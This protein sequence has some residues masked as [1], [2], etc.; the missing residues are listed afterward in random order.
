MIH[1][2]SNMK[3]LI[4]ASSLLVIAACSLNAQMFETVLEA[5]E[6]IFHPSHFQGS[7]EAIVAGDG[8]MAVGGN[9]LARDDDNQNI[10]NI[11]YT[12]TDGVTF[13][14]AATTVDGSTRLYSGAFGGGRFVFGGSTGEGTTLAPPQ[15]YATSTDGSNWEMDSF[16]D[17]E[18]DGFFE[19]QGMAYGDGEFVG[20][21]PGAALYT[22]TNGSDW[23]TTISTVGTFG[24]TYDGEQF[25][26]AGG[27]VGSAA[28]PSGAW[29]REA[30]LTGQAEEIAYGEGAYVTAGKNI[31]GRGLI[32][33]SED[34]ETWEYY[35]S[36]LSVNYEDLYSAAGYFVAVGGQFISYSSDG[37]TWTD[38][39]LLDEGISGGIT[40]VGYAMG[41]WYIGMNAGGSAFDPRI[42]RATDEFPPQA[43]SG[44]SGGGSVGGL[45]TAY[46]NAIELGGGWYWDANLGP[47]YPLVGSQWAY[48]MTAGWIYA[49]G[50]Y[51][52]QLYFYSSTSQSWYY[53]S[54]SINGLVYDFSGGAWLQYEGIS[55]SYITP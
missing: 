50:D 2:K 27:S 11:I 41:H 19:M 48:T 53:T 23:T 15:Y 22:T 45:A 21:G 51:D 31:V 16:R 26:V 12:S 7:F 49:S 38:I 13:Q 3:I 40:S 18:G 52:P 46:D 36:G 30:V 29:T 6:D 25:V 14:P 35:E 9:I 5:P 43:D 55:Q 34:L 28:D 24:A 37:V 10:N 8:V 44:D 39:N 32:G 20:I 47:F 42:L 1:R 33:Y 4:K 17:H 54:K